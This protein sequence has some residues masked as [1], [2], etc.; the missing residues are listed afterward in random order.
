MASDI[1]DSAIGKPEI[2][3]RTSSSSPWSVQ[4]GYLHDLFGYGK[5]LYQNGPTTYQASPLTTQAQSIVSGNSNPNSLYGQ[6]Q[7]QLGDTISGK[8]LDP[9]TNPYLSSSVNDALGLAKTQFAGLYGGPAGQNVGNTGF[10]EQ[11]ARTLGQTATNA[12]AGHYGQERQ[13]QLNAAQLGGQFDLSQANALSQ[14]G[15]QDLQLQRMNALS[16]WANLAGYQ[17]AVAGNYGGVGVSQNPWSSQLFERLDPLN[18]SNSNGG[19]LGM[20][21]GAGQEAGAG[22]AMFASD[23]RVK[24][25]IERIGTHDSGI[26]IYKYTYKGSDTPQ[27]GVLAQELETVKP[28]AVAEIGGIKHVNYK[29]I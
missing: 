23:V 4:Q 2:Q 15:Q 13:N 19:I 12:Y 27:I 6:S 10:Q 18:P 9:N 3:E 29:M 8:Y 26:G 11:L 5:Q 21:G 17:G 22:M 7:S 25:N 28:E 14:L 24:D 16:P 1:F 20:S